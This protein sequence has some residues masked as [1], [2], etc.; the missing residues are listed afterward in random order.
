MKRKTPDLIKEIDKLIDLGR[1]LIEYGKGNPGKTAPE[2]VREF[3]FWTTRTGELLSSIYP[4]DINITKHIT[5][6]GK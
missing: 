6:L 2:K 4:K 3:T 5:S 1:Q